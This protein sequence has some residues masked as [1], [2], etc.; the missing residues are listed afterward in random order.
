[1]N[2]A[3]QKE[4]NKQH[5]IKNK[6]SEKERSNI[7]Y[8]KNK[9]K[10]KRIRMER[11]FKNFELNKEKYRAQGRNNYKKHKLRF[12]K[13][14]ARRQRKLGYESLNQPF[15]GSVG[16][17][18]D[19]VRVINIPEELHKSIRHSVLRNENME[20]INQLAWNFMEASVL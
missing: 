13:S 6:E 8:A 14:V 15:E 11:Y 4:Y 1:M 9:E 17:H 5:Y 2:Q 12:Y 16:H 3:Q 19:R 7:Y 10:R 18:I 20:A